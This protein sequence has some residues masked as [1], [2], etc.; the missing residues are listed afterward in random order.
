MSIP[1]GVRVVVWSTCKV[2][3]HRRGS[4]RIFEYTRPIFADGQVAVEPCGKGPRLRGKVPQGGAAAGLVSLSTS[5]RNC[6]KY[7]S[8]RINTG[9]QAMF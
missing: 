8:T 7:N 5:C 3:H 1:Q 2:V 4:G 9:C 6:Y